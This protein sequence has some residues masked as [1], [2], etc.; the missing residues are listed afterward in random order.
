MVHSFLN[1]KII[2]DIFNMTFQI[3]LFYEFF[4]SSVK[5]KI[6]FYCFY[7][8]LSWNAELNTYTLNYLKYLVDEL[9]MKCMFVEINVRIKSNILCSQY[10]HENRFSE[11]KKDCAFNVLIEL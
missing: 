7:F 2:A 3:D 6:V 9:D 8:A 4:F 11:K 1:F 10:K 5:S